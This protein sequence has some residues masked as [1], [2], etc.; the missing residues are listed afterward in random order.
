[1]G[2]IHLIGPKREI[3]KTDSGNLKIVSKTL[4]PRF[5]RPERLRSIADRFNLDQ[6]QV[7]ENVLYARAYNSEHQFELLNNVAMKLH[8]E[9]GVFKLL[10]ID[11][12]MALFRV[13]FSGRGEIADRQQKLAQMMSRLQK[14]SE[15]YNVAVFITNQITSD[16]NAP[17]LQGDV[18]KPVGGNIIAHA[19]TTRVSLRK[20]AGSK[21]IAKIYDSPDLEEDEAAYAITSGGINDPVD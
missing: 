8:E 2:C 12:I 14:I 19:S 3:S 17:V 7:L 18:Q 16:L 4:T 5:S 21:R 13:D 10:I 1:M 6:N 15:E 20:A 9:A 11:S